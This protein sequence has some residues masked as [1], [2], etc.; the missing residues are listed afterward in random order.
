[1]TNS[2]LYKRS[3]FLLFFLLPVITYS[4]NYDILL[5][6]ALK[7]Y[8]FVRN[9]YEPTEI[10]FLM[11]NNNMGGLADHSGLGFKEIWLNSLWKNG[12][13]RIPLQGPYLTCEELS[14]NNVSEYNQNLNIRNGVLSTKVLLNNGKGYSSNV[15]FSEKDKNLLVLNIEN[16]SREHQLKF[17]VNLPENLSNPKQLNSGTIIGE[18]TEE[19]FTQ[20]KWYFKSSLSIEYEN[21]SFYIELSKGESITVFLSIF[22]NRENV[23]YNN[24]FAGLSHRELAFKKRHKENEEIWEGYWNQCAAVFI[25][26]K[27]MEKL[28]YRS[29]FWLLCTAGNRD[30][31]PGENQFAS[32]SWGMIPFSYGYAGWAMH[33]FAS[34]GFPERARNMAISHYKPEALRR[35]AALFIPDEIR[36]NDEPMCFAHQVTISGDLDSAGVRGTR[37]HKD[38]YFSRPNHTQHNL[39]GFVSAGYNLI[40]RYFP[41]KDFDREYTLPALKGTAEFWRNLVYWD[42]SQPEMQTYLLPPFQSVSENH[43][44]VSVLDGVLA[45][46]WNLYR[47]YELGIKYNEF[48]YLRTKWK[49]V[50]EKM[51]IPQNDSYYLEFFGDDQSRSGGG[52]LGM[53]AHVWLGYPALETIKFMDSAKVFNSLDES[54]KRNKYGEGMI[55]FIANWFAL[56]EAYFNRGEEALL[57]ARHNLTCIDPSGVALCE[58]PSGGRPYF[59]TGVAS[60]VLIPLSM[61]VQSYDKEIK[62]FPAMP[63]EFKDVE[64]YNIPAESGIR[65]SGKMTDGK[66]NWIK[67]SQNGKEL[68]NTVNSNKVKIKG[69]GNNLFLDQ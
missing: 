12:W 47:A 26:D 59:L 15:F 54:W 56:T 25:P 45:A 31:L 37:V 8:S 46:K 5:K 42:E 32:P 40:S 64:F 16:T 24:A 34:L 23:N 13:T 62:V 39:T 20:V 53:R 35:N 3:V 44:A 11:G 41:D 36:I 65:V 30:F 29:V 43:S 21:D 58:T 10:G 1:M 2:F 49:A 55:T 9:K 69:E 22:T 28:Y 57:K 61:V 19:N 66:I 63:D 51:Y 67:Y 7:Q 6:N 33:A 14:K 38:H 27:D 48:E 50:S 18:T 4:Q 68:L 60:Y 52:Y 17:K